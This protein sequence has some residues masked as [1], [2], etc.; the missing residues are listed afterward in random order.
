MYQDTLETNICLT[1]YD[2]FCFV[3][4][5]QFVEALKTTLPSVSDEESESSHV[6]TAAY[7]LPKTAVDIESPWPGWHKISF[8]VVSHPGARGNVFSLILGF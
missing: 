3:F 7:I 5:F 6:C 8:V 4:P 2:E 1:G